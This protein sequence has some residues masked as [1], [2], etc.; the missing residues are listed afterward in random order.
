[1][2]EREMLTSALAATG[3]NKAEAARK[4]GLPRSTFYSKLKK[5]QI[6]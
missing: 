2:E 4:L 5:H 3:G 6:A 1:M